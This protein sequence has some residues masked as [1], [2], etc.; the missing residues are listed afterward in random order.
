MKKKIATIALVAA[1]AAIAVGGTLAFYTAEE[2]AHNVITTGGIDIEL[3]EKHVLPSGE[4]VDFPGEVFNV[5]PGVD[6]SKIVRVHNVGPS[7]AW[8]RASVTFQV[9]DVNKAPLPAQLD[10]GTPVLG[11]TVLD[12]WA[13]GADGRYY[14]NA[15]LQPGAQTLPLISAVTFDVRVGN[16][17]QNATAVVE[18]KV[19]AVQTANNGGT[20]AQAQGWPN[21][22][23]FDSGIEE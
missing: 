7:E 12:G 9:F 6:V 2:T 22:G 15:P 19:D 13:Q 1:V 21:G 10:D 8:V 18:V 14:C 16:E 3:V 23:S 5:C 4:T 20:V 11:Y 17:Y